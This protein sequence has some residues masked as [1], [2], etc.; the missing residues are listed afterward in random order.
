M[1]KSAY[2]LKGFAPLYIINLDDQPER[3]EYMETQ[4]KYW[5]VENY[6]LVCLHMMVVK[7]I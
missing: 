7:M 6:T 4:F 2:K 1:N 3:W 5:E